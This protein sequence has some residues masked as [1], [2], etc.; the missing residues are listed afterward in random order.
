MI[1]FESFETRLAGWVALRQ[2]IEDHPDPFNHVIAFWNKAPISPRSCDPFDKESWPKA[3]D[4]IEEN[5][6]CDFSKILAM[7]YTFLLTDRYKDSYYEIRIVNDRKEHRMMYL[8]IIDGN[9]IGYDYKNVVNIVDLPKGLT[10]QSSH[11]MMYD[12]D[13]R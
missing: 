4:L 9:V 8:L 5:K 3:W 13:L 2:E 1:F 11:V 7:Y 6:F 12:E 10:T